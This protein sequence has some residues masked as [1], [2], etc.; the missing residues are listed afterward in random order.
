[1]KKKLTL[2]MLTILIG[3]AIYVFASMWA[4]QTGYYNPDP[5]K[6]DANIGAGLIA[7]VGMPISIFGCIWLVIELVK[8]GL[9]RKSKR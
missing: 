4:N 2:P 3:A 8:L 1:M 6:R 7:L 5:A 9:S